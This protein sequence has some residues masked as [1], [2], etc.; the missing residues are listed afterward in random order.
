MKNK[1]FPNKISCLDYDASNCDGCAVGDKFIKQRK[2]IAR[3]EEEKATLRERLEKAVEFKAK[4]GDTLYIPWV[5]KGSYDI[6][7]VTVSVVTKNLYGVS[8]YDTNL[9]SDDDDFLRKYN[10]G[11]FRDSDFGVN[12]FMSRKTAVARL[13]AELKGE[14]E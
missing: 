3:L 13:F 4:V 9:D 2:R 7:Q 11:Q 10:Y 1:I 8:C 6:A 12:V 5:W 14:K